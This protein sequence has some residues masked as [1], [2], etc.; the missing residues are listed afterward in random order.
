MSSLADLARLRELEQRMEALEQ[1]IAQLEDKPAL[2]TRETLSLRKDV[3]N[4]Q[5]GAP[6]RD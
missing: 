6:R 3:S 4:G 1:R 2:L 5:K